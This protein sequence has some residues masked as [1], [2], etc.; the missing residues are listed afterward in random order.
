MS[1]KPW[2]SKTLWVNV[3]AFLSFLLGHFMG[4]PISPAK[5]GMILAAL[6]FG[7]RFITK[8]SIVGE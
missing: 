1:K 8:T 7:L 3:I 5:Q 6:N 4:M 2:Q